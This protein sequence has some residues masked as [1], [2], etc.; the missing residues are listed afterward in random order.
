MSHPPHACSANIEFSCYGDRG[1]TGTTL[2]D[3][4]DGNGNEHRA[5]PMDCSGERGG[6]RELAVNNQREKGDD[7]NWTWKWTCMD[8]TTDSAEP[9]QDDNFLSKTA[10]LFATYTA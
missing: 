3:F 5:I 1:G 8:G 10:T 4:P 6:F 7:D 9:D 2:I